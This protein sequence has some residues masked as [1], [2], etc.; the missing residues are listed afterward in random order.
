MSTRTSTSATA[1][2]GRRL[3]LVRAGWV[4]V[5][6]LA[7]GLFVASVPS[8]VSG[9]IELGQADWMGAPVEAPTGVVLVFDLLGVLA[10]CAT[11]VLCLTLAAVLFRRR[12]DDWMVVFIS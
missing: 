2:R 10:S 3:L 8:Y 9:V 4:L 6:T 5:A 12:S 1:L 11:V 7:L